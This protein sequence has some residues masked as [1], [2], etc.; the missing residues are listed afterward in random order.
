VQM[1]F[2]PPARAIAITGFMGT[3]KSSVSKHVAVRLG[4]ECVDTDELVERNAGA[5]ISE[6][7]ARHGEAH[8][9]DLESAALREALGGG[10][11]VVST[12]GGML[13]RGENLE[14]LREAGPIVCLEATPEA[15]L[16][17]TSSDST[18]PLLA[19]TDETPSEAVARLLDE[20]APVYA[21]ADYQVETTAL[22]QE[23]AAEHIVALLA[24]D[25]RGCYFTGRPLSVPVDLEEAAYTIRVREGLLGEL[26]GLC[27]ADEPGVQAAV[28]S[29]DNI[30]DLYGDLVLG[31]LAEGGWAPTLLTVPDGER[32]KCLG[33]LSRLY[34]G[35]AQAGVDRGGCV[36]ALGGGVVGDLAGF[37]AAT[38]LRG[39]DLIHLP[40]SLLA[41]VD[42]SIGG[43]TAVDLPQGKNLVG[44]FHQPRMVVSDVEV[45]R[46]LP[47][48]EFRSGL[49]EIIKH[50]CCLDAE[51]FE[52]LSRHREHVV[53]LDG[54]TL[55]YLVARNC[56]IKG[57]VVAQDPLDTGLRAVLNYG[58]TVGHAIE[59]AAQDW[60][61]RHGEAVALGIVAESRVAH[62]LGLSDGDMAAR[63]E[64]L[65]AEYGLPVSLRELDYERATRALHHDKK[66][67][68]GRLRLPLVP[69]LGRFEIVA[70]VPLELVER[71]LRSL[72]E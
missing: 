36:F 17:R 72:C 53:S 19:G 41:Q 21:Q 47:E 8:F 63:Q 46:T 37:A 11:L 14:L 58:H 4:L 68:S 3:G 67:V 59:R 38:Y 44:A 57:E 60:E 18:R 61:L 70:D 62:W 35:L 13:L 2:A 23:Q 25:S 54:P 28:I 39:I 69:A 22:T 1:R 64:Q 45:L 49:A 32:S 48:V 16:E 9:R 20:R 30:A 26:G 33:E 71:A 24:D 42:S 56:Q 10:R 43:K 51:M 6:V 55:E 50:A 27:P 52:Y 66:I 15:I 31:S 29:S 12:G 7:F 34:Q 65:V 40:T 5:T